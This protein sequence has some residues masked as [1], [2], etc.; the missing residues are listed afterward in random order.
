MLHVACI[1]RPL[2]R[3]TY[4]SCRVSADNMLDEMLAD[5]PD[6]FSDVDE[7]VLD[8][9]TRSAENGGQHHGAHGSNLDAD[10]YPDQPEGTICLSE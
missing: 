6:H 9:G 4:D 7:P 3:H 1:C 5:T 2:G 10:R 8:A